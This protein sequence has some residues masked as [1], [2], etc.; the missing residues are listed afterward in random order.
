MNEQ[1]PKRTYKDGLFRKLFN[2]K[3]AL[4]SLYSALSGK[5]YPANTPIRIVTLDEVL[6]G[7]L[8]NDVAFII[9]NRL[10]ILVEHQSTVNPNMPFRM[11]CYLAKEFEKEV[12]SNAV[13]SK[14]LVQIPTPELYVFYNGKDDVPLEQ[15]LK[16]SDAFFEKRDTIYVEVL[17]R[18]INVNYEKG[19][20]LLAQC[21]LLKE[22]SIL[23]Y[24][25]R[26]RYKECGDLKDAI[27][28][29]IRECI[30]DGV[31]AAFLK[32]NGGD[33]MSFLY[34]ALTREECEAIREEDGYVRGLE[35]GRQMGV[36]IGSFKAFKKMV[37][38]GIL[39]LDRAA[40]QMEDQKDEFMAWYHE[41]HKI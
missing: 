5:D 3:K 12:Y 26:C 13:Y 33:V 28:L 4:L 34:Q 19:A 23:I 10:I 8:K 27:A 39:S 32:R 20:K 38:Q 1:Q 30:N 40:T 14:T 37:D 31:L 25:I 9:E 22:Y 24:K 6:F 35:E 11:L 21:K 15:E 36:R 16:L 41:N 17:I 18:V 7:D 29:S 2:N